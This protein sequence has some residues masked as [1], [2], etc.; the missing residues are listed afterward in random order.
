MP[1]GFQTFL[2]PKFCADYEN[3]SHFS[4]TSSVYKIFQKTGIPDFAYVVVS[5]ESPC[6]I[7]FFQMSCYLSGIH[8]RT[9]LWRCI[10]E[11]NFKKWKLAELS[12]LEHKNRGIFVCIFSTLSMFEVHFCRDKYMG[13]NLSVHWWKGIVILILG[14]YLFTSRHCFLK[15]MKAVNGKTRY[16]NLKSGIPVFLNTF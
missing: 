5:S 11:N 15:K 3:H 16:W 10:R 7:I 13:P 1:R 9:C 8:R 4:V 2:G 6:T 14:I 12:A